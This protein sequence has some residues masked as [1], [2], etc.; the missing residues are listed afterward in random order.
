[1]EHNHSRDHVTENSMYFVSITQQFA[2]MLDVLK[3]QPSIW[4][5]SFGSPLFCLERELSKRK[6]KVFH[7]FPSR[8]F[9]FLIRAE[10]HC[11]WAYLFNRSMHNTITMPFISDRWQHKM[12]PFK[13]WTN[14]FYVEIA[15]TIHRYLYIIL[16]CEH[17]GKWSKRITVHYSSVA[18]FSNMF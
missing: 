8:R 14:T 17:R 12:D 3:R 15:I 4:I 7:H 16:H 18:P 2:R 1:M 13:L 11:D 6:F 5:C 10:S 9:Q